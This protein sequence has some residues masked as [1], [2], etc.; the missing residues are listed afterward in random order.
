MA[1]QKLDYGV[2]IAMNISELKDK[3]KIFKVILKQNFCK[4][5]KI[6]INF[7]SFSDF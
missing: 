6:L 1:M 4:I 5:L 2:I 7:Y 3:N